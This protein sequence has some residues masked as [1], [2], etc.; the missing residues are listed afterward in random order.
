LILCLAGPAPA[1]IRTILVSPVPGDPVASGT[2]LRNALAGISSPSSTNRWLVKIEPGIYDVA[3]TSLLM[4]SWVDVE[5]S[6]IGTTTIRG[7]V[8]GSS[9]VN[10][11][12][13]GASSAELRLVTVEATGTAEAIAMYNEFASPRLYRVKLLAQGSA[14]AWGMRNF[15]SA[16][17]VEECEI[18]ASTSSPTGSNAYGIVFRGVVATGQRS[19]I[20]RSK[21]DAAN[22]ASNYGLFMMEAQTVTEIRD[23][24]INAT[25][26]SNTYGIYATFGPGGWTGQE[27]LALRDV[28]VSSAGGSSASYG[29]LLDSNS[30][31]AMSIMTSTLWGHV[32][33][34]TYGIVQRVDAPMG[35]QGASV[36]GFTKTIDTAGSISIASTHLQGGPTTALG[37]LGCMGVWDENGVFYANSCPP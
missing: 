24:K 12:I 22:A 18:A 17:I 29:A 13:H 33:P 1:Q 28:E 30:W 26:G 37:W 3:A 10:A 14:G 6:G 31:V 25:G 8:D 35:L 36:T 9:L 34:A 16:P 7:T 21:I 27:N 4:R 5:G 2:G 20:V 23:S 15:A 19:S 11:T 32:S